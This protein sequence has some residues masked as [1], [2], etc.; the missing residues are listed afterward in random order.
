M[1]WL[2]AAWAVI[3]P[4][5]IVLQMR[6]RQRYGGFGRVPPPPA[7]PL[8]ASPLTASPPPASPPPASPLPSSAPGADD[9]FS[10]RGGAWLNG[11]NVTWPGA[12]L[13]VT[14]DGAELDVWGADLIRI[15]R[16]EVTSLHWVPGY[17]P[18]VGLKFRTESGRLDKVTFWF[19]GRRPD[20][21]RELGWF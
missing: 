21:L 19:L 12:T 16:A 9:V 17:R 3:G 10:A 4:V 13:R 7:S 20:R 1:G 2:M 6:R 8:P 14:R 5:I 18:G 11:W 15:S